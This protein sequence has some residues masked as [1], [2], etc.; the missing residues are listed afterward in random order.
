MLGEARPEFMKQDGKWIVFT[1]A[2]V[3]FSGNFIPIGWNVVMHIADMK[4]ASSTTGRICHER[5]STSRFSYQRDPRDGR[6]EGSS[7]IAS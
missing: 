6:I 4:R 7:R 3:N 1:R 5:Q 2:F